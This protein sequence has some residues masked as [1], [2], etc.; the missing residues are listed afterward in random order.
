MVHGLRFCLWFSTYTFWFAAYTFLVRDLRS[1]IPQRNPQEQESKNLFCQS[2]KTPAITGRC[3]SAQPRE[4]A[5]PPQAAS[6]EALPQDAVLQ[7]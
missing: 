6:P 7:L 2:R 3:P 5:A 1:K 4:P